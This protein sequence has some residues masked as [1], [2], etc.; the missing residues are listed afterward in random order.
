MVS[1]LAFKIIKNAVEI[2]VSRNESLDDILA[3]YPK[4]S[5]KQVAKIRSKF[6]KT[7]E[8]N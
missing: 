4:L 8:E 2:R 1:D 6:E 5:E 3:S 7:K